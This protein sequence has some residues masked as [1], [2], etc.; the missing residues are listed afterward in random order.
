VPQ[1][2]PS[3]GPRKRSRGRVFV[4][5]LGWSLLTTLALLGIGGGFVFL[6][7]LNGS[8]AN[9]LP[10]WVLPLVL[11]VGFPVILALWKHPKVPSQALPTA[12]N[13]FPLL[14]SAVVVIAIILVPESVGSALRRLGLD[15][16]ERLGTSD[17][18]AQVVS[19]WG[20]NLA[21]RVSPPPSEP[22]SATRSTSR[23]A[24]V[25]QPELPG[26]DPQN[27]EARPDPEGTGDTD[28]AAKD[29]E[30][31]GALG[32]DSDNEETQEGIYV[33]FDPNGT[34]ITIPATLRGPGGEKTVDYL[35]DT[36]ATFTTITPALAEELGVHV[37]P[38]APTQAFNTAKGP[39][40]TPM[41]YLDALTLG[42]VTIRGVL[43]AVCEDCSSKRTE[44]LLGLNVTRNF[45]VEMDYQRQEM[46]LDP[47]H[48]NNSGNRAF[49][50]RHIL[51]LRLAGIPEV[52]QG[53]IS[54]SLEV[55]NLS[56]RDVYD[57]VPRVEFTTDTTLFGSRISH[58]P[59]R[60]TAR[61]LVRGRVFREGER[62][63]VEYVL[64]LEQ[65]RWR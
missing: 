39:A 24:S 46:H 65:G 52:F 64:S 15:T 33:Q 40:N 6:Y 10:R 2:R 13:L 60:S 16:I 11:S 22:D 31:L 62:P 47:R 19:A 63:E 29:R 21:D 32:G 18:R 35:F 61:S 9:L 4:D 3:I 59:A 34:G 36:G 38:D 14:N 55:E 41:V 27:L 26:A 48:F 30:S 56:H 51:N 28:Q 25:P 42:D 17:R 50:I 53:Y 49:D 58:L 5:A 12:L 44:G 45:V 23:S 7:M 8:D 43:V 37:R 1:H 54:W 20:M 57:V